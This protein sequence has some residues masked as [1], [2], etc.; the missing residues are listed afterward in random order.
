MAQSKLLRNLRHR[1]ADSVANSAA[2]PPPDAM[3]FGA[4]SGPSASA[5]L[6][7]ELLHADDPA[8]GVD[9]EPPTRTLLASGED[10][11]FPDHEPIV[12]SR[13]FLEAFRLNEENEPITVE[14]ERVP[15]PPAPPAAHV[16]QNTFVEHPPLRTARN[17]S[18]PQLVD[19]GTSVPIAAATATAMQR[20]SG[21][22]P[23]DLAQRRKDRAA[24]VREKEERARL[25][26]ERA[27]AR[28]ARVRSREAREARKEARRKRNEARGVDLEPEL[29]N[30]TYEVPLD[31]KPLYPN[32]AASVEP[33]M[34]DFDALSPQ[35]TPQPQPQPPLSHDPLLS[36]GLDAPLL[37]EPAPPRPPSVQ[38]AV[39]PTTRSDPP[40]R[41]AFMT[42]TGGSP[43]MQLFNYDVT[44]LT[45]NAYIIYR[46][47]FLMLR[48]VWRW[49]QPWVTGGIAAFYLVVWWRGQLL[50][51]F[52]LCTFLYVATFRLFQ[53]PPEETIATRAF[54]SGSNL[55][56][57]SSI[58]SLVSLR[59]TKGGSLGQSQQYSQTT[60]QQL[61]DQVLIVTHHL[62][63][64]FERTKNFALW[65][66]PWATARYLGWIL[67]FAILS[68]HMT[69]WMFVK[70]PGLFVF[71]C[72]FGVAPLVEYGYWRRV[73]DV[74]SDMHHMPRFNGQTNSVLEY[75]LYGVPSDEEHYRYG[76]S[77][78]LWE[79]DHEQR[80]RGMHID[81][82]SN[83]IV[84]VYDIPTDEGIK[85]RRAPR[86]IPQRY[87]DAVDVIDDPAVLAE[88]LGEFKPESMSDEPAVAPV[89]HVQVEQV[90]EAP[91]QD[92]PLD[93]APLKQESPEVPNILSMRAATEPEYSE[94]VVPEPVVPEPAVP[95]PVVPE[96]VAQDASL[97]SAEKAGSFPPRPVLG[98]SPDL[99]TPKEP[100]V[101]WSG[102]SRAR[103]P[104]PFRSPERQEPALEPLLTPE[105]ASIPLSAPSSAPVRQS[106][107]GYHTIRRQTSHNQIGAPAFVPAQSD[108]LRS[109]LERRRRIK[110]HKKET[111]ANMRQQDSTLFSRAADPSPALSEDIIAPDSAQQTA[112]PPEP[113]MAA[114][115]IPAPVKTQRIRWTDEKQTQ[116]LAV[117]RRR[118][119]HL[120]VLP[121]R[122]VFVLTHS[123]IK[124]IAPVSDM[125]PAEE[126]MLTKI[127]DGRYYYPIIAPS[128]LEDMVS[129]EQQGGPLTPFDPF[130]VLGSTKPESA[131]VLFDIPVSNISGLRKT[132]KSTPVLDNCVEG[133]EILTSEQ[134]FALPAVLQ[135]DLAFQTIV[136][137]APRRW[138]S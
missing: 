133:I 119:G 17:D 33:S 26:E 88:S 99:F 20:A 69:T 48:R 98:D 47:A 19:D 103:E 12:R 92:A 85:R 35:P 89:E 27:R 77:R 49:E 38:S 10:M 13:S 130:T 25:R 122:V 39:V 64:L 23:N 63:N 66:N 102:A 34:S 84:G 127:L 9:D 29:D 105:S 30:D 40:A 94:P 136:E 96:P 32:L 101:L 56:R 78:S 72:F 75:V 60:Y 110:D 111:L 137:L 100:A 135:R 11:G 116:F 14:D 57:T 50:A 70:L 43:R 44:R 106:A 112:E 83:M 36:P 6:M 86:K 52:F 124:P 109:H 107:P 55:R 7:G 118:L 54:E 4:S 90:T 128:V 31:T 71:F 134:S 87:S 129:A 80:R 97:H 53:P 115:P 74:Y 22:S 113:S 114:S 95:E 46:G 126:S 121:T 79:R 93:Y 82:G 123:A 65:R 104:S 117:H 41:P 68:I 125:T 61:G 42:D 28:E 1:A 132:R 108:T 18:M 59:S 3:A 67:L 62:A 24:R 58:S 2:A 45:I 8:A 37:S 76:L 131:Q 15:A 16:Q 120:V 21:D 5:R 138:G 91:W 51:M 81:Q 73:L